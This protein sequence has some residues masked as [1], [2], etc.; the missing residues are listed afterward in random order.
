MACP[1][2]AYLGGYMKISQNGINLIKKWEGFRSHAYLCPSGVWTCGYGTTRGVTANT[3][4]DEKTAEKFLYQDITSFEV[5]LNSLVKV[6]L[7]Q[8]QYDAL[9]SL[10]YNIGVGAFKNSTL[11]KDLN[12]RNY[13]LAG[14]EFSR[15]VYSGN[16]V[17]QGLVNRR[18]DEFSLFDKK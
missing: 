17:L 9:L 12:A 1:T 3:I 14:H 8:N 5:A 10:M 11:L 18:K 13:Y 4:F 16:N 6:P 15:W 7:T 2:L